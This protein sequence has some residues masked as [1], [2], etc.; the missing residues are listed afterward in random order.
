M[1]LKEYKSLKAGDKIKFIKR[2]SNNIYSLAKIGD[3]F[4][5]IKISSYVEMIRLKNGDSYGISDEKNYG[6]DM[7]YYNY[8]EKCKTSLKEFL[9]NGI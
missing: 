1:N 7:K 9:E 6:E 8:F 4:K 2:P 3:I 5:I